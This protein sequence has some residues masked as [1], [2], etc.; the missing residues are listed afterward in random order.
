MAGGWSD[1]TSSYT[2]TAS[3]TDVW[4]VWANDS[5][6][7]AGSSTDVIWQDWTSGTSSSIT[8]NITYATPRVSSPPPETEEEKQAREERERQRQERIRVERELEKIATEKAMN[9]LLDNLDRQQKEMFEKTKWFFVVGQSGK[10]YRIRHGWTGNIDEL[11]EKDMVVAEY[12][13]HPESRVPIAD[14]MLIQKLMLE[15]DEER[16]KQIANKTTLR[17]PQPLAV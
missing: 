13:I 2:T 5:G 6:T 7:S 10:K 12:C 1:T 15:A 17:T 9:L 11:D 4:Y 16:F 8:S 14:S 3:S